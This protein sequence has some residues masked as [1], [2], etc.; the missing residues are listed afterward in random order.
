VC[1]VAFLASPGSIR[2]ASSPLMLRSHIVCSTV[3]TARSGAA[4]YRST[5]V[6][7]PR[8]AQTCF[9]PASAMCGASLWLRSIPA[10]LRVSNAKAVQRL[11][12]QLVCR[13]LSRQRPVVNPPAASK[14]LREQ[15]LL[16]VVGVQPVFIGSKHCV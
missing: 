13:Y 12:G 15:Q 16:R 9:Q 7:M 5:T 4:S 3:R 14:V 11:P 6:C 8:T 10:M 1:T 2:E